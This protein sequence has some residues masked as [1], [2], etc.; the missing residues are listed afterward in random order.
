VNKLRITGLLKDKKEKHKCQVLT[1][2][3]LG[4]IW[5]RLEHT[6][7]ESLKCLAQET[8][9]SMSS[10]RMK[11]ELLNLKPYKTTVIRALQ[12]CDPASRVH[13]CSWFLQSATGGGI[14][15]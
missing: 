2:K 11:T 14:H 8:G 15:N 1:E 13:F 3:K 6:P 7:T 12:R 5:A 4:D 10:A 9:V